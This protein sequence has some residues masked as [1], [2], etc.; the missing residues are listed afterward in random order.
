MISRR[1]KPQNQ[2]ERQSSAIDALQAYQ[3][4]YGRTQ[5]VES[6]FKTNLLVK[7][8]TTFGGV[9][10]ALIL[11]EQLVPKAIHS[12][13]LP[14]YKDNFSILLPVASLACWGFVQPR[15]TVFR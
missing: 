2:L 8:P 13:H 14:N 4:A 3:I 7:G 10:S 5:E 9:L 12:N 11:S 15:P 1:A 6:P